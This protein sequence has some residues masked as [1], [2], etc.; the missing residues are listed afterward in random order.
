MKLKLLAG[1]L[2]RA[3]KPAP[4]SG[5]VNPCRLTKPRVKRGTRQNFSVS[6]GLFSALCVS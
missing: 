1:R 5:F 4:L 6:S 3:R 2:H